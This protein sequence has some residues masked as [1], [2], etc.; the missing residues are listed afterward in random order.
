MKL[1]N[2]LETV[3]IRNEAE[4]HAFAAAFARRLNKTEIICF[5][6][7]LGAGKSSF[8][9]ELVRTLCKDAH[10]EVPSP[11]FTLVQIYDF[12][13]GNQQSS[14]THFDLYRLV[15]PSEIYELGWEEALSNG[16]VL[17][18]WPERLGTLLPSN[19]IDIKI[20]YT[21]T[22]TNQRMINLERLDTERV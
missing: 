20:S 2:G 6:G 8:C 19:R 15:D 17:V 11:T 10:L 13:N 18:E 3:L 1:F 21:P 4:M 22:D 7:D 12:I 9:R 5:Y 14:I 16:I